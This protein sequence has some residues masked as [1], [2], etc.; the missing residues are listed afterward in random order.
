MAV[1]GLNW[2]GSKEAGNAPP[3]ANSNGDI[4]WLGAPIN[5]APR[6]G[7]TV[8]VDDANGQYMMAPPDYGANDTW[9]PL[10]SAKEP[11]PT[12]VPLPTC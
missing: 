4:T 10:A 11:Y 9:N 7:A 3:F 1:F 6:C 2:F 8:P 5:T 12:T